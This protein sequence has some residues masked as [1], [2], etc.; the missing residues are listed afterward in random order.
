MKNPYNKAFLIPDA[1]V[2]LC[3]VKKLSVK[4]IIWNTQGVNKTKKPK[5]NAVKNMDNKPLFSFYSASG[6]ISFF[7]TVF[8]SSS[9]KFDGSSVAVV[10]VDKSKVTI[11]L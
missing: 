11:L 7:T 1:L 9:I 5:K 6:L 4:G 8:V 10:A 3:F 2:L